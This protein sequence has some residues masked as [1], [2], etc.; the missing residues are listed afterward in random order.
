MLA[1]TNPA[2]SAASA[3]LAN[4]HTVAA[5]TNRYD[6]TTP[7]AG[8]TSAL[9]V[10]LHI[11]SDSLLL[12]KRDTISTFEFK[13]HAFLLE[14]GRR[15]LLSVVPLGSRLKTGKFRDEHGVP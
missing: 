8:R 5:W 4:V 1:V 3:G 11:V 9:A 2:F 7:V 15:Y 13:H 6:V 10:G 12:K 14:T